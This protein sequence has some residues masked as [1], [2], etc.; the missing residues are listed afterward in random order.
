MAVSLLYIVG[1]TN[2][3]RGQHGVIPPSLTV[4]LS[5]S[6]PLGLDEVDIPPWAWTQERKMW[7]QERKMWPL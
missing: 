7:T 3:H 6:H 4:G 5:H 2:V 1:K